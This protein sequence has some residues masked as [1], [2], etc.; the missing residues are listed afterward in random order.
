[1]QPGLRNR[2]AGLSLNSHQ[3]SQHTGDERLVVLRPSAGKSMSVQRPGN[4]LLQA[5]PAAEFEVLR[6]HLEIVELVRETVL[7]EA[8]PADARLPASQ[9]R[10]LDVGPP[11]GRTNGRGGDGRPRQRFRRLGRARRRDVA[12]HRGSSFCRAQPPFSVTNAW[13]T[14]LPSSSS[15]MASSAP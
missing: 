2:T 10:D 8:Q 6:P 5:L 7:V 11:L 12:D 1:V 13:L 15:M 4:H 14:R 9:R 3:T